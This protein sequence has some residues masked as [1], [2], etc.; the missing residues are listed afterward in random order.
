MNLKEYIIWL[1]RHYC[2]D[3]SYSNIKNKVLHDGCRV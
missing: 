1:E 2:D 3:V